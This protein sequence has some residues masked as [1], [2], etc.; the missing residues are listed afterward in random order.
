[1]RDEA[2]RSPPARTDTPSDPGTASLA[3][4][5]DS[6]YATLA[7]SPTHE[8]I[9]REALGEGYAGQIGYAGEAELR[10]LAEV[11]GVAPGRRVLELCCGT[12]GASSWLGAALGAQA[13]GIDCSRGGLRLA[14]ATDERGGRPA[15]AAFVAGDLERLPF[16]D[17]SLDGMLC[18][19]GFGT[20]FDGVAR[21]AVR[22]LRPGGG[23][24]ILVSLPPDETRGAVEAFER[25]GLTGAFA[26]DRTGSAAPLMT[27]WLDA[28]RR[29]REA[30]VREVGERIHRGLVEEIERLL[31]G[32]GSGSVQR[33]LLAARR[34]ERK[35]PEPVT[36][37]LMSGPGAPQ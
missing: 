24:A 27:R 11:A 15:T 19:D 8:A 20:G 1:V 17:A 14:R 3:R 36:R 34:P 32:Y 9:G 18:I 2:R 30:H 29:H 23:L 35:N 26:E 16:A 33:V 21:Q 7:A 5:F 22:M 13:V 10:R 6:L 12:G 25:E 37:S 28:Y 31:D 4:Y